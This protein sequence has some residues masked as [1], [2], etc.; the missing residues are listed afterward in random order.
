M[1]VRGG[2]RGTS[3][4]RLRRWADLGA[5]QRLCLRARFGGG[6]WIC[7]RVPAWRFAYCFLT[8]DPA[9]PVWVQTSVSNVSSDFSDFRGH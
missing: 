8:P 4:R 2:G 7:I 3:W 5:P 6:R 9:L 1:R